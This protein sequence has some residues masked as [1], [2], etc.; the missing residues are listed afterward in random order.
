MSSS[1]TVFQGSIPGIYDRCLGP[2]LFAP[3]AA[4]LAAR[5]AAG[6]PHDIL[7]TA[8]GTGIVTAALVQRLPDADIVATD[9]NAAMLEVAAARVGDGKVRFRPADAQQL[10]FD[11]ASFDAVVCQFGVM[12]FPDRIGASR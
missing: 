12:F 2:L 5:V 4:D 10:P 7:E 3:F 8:A 6:R 1:D 11:D 9:L